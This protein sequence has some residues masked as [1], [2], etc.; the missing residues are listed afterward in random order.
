[1]SVEK[2][3]AINKAAAK[4]TATSKIVT[5]WNAVKP[6]LILAK[7][8]LGFFVPKIVPAVDTFIT[9]IDA[10]IANGLLK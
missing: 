4:V 7:Q 3:A 5:I 9:A 6:F 1:M 2:L 8:T 10:A